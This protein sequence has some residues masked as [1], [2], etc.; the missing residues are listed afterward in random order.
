MAR[1]LWAQ[2]LLASF[3]S[4]QSSYS[5]ANGADGLSTVAGTRTATSA[6]ATL[7]GS[8]TQYSVA[9]TVPASADVGA[10][11]LPNIKDPSA[12]QAQQLCPGY[13]ASNVEH[14][15]SGIKGR[16]SLS[17][18]PCNVYGTDIEELTIEVDIQTAHR[19]R[20]SIQP[21]YL[22]ASNVSQYILPDHLINLPKQGVA[23]PDTQDIDL[24]FSYSN[25]PTFSFKVVR[26]STGDV[27]FDTTGSVLVFENQFIEFV[28]QMP[29]N[30]NLYGLGEQI[31]GL[32]L[33]NNYTATV[34]L[35]YLA[36]S[37]KTVD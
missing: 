1:L 31:H 32:R 22:S 36:F 11:V 14:T 17:G 26:K 28:T 23:Q 9:F 21:A 18:E 30:Y 13:T 35:C 15:A 19:L 2:A 37:S 8:T 12:K 33:G 25:D 7:A 3:V 29:E 10:N 6:T 24:Q 5:S 27:L 20:L 34:R 16:L 4:A